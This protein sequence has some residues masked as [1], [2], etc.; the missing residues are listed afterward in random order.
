[1]ISSPKSYGESWTVG[2]HGPY[3]LNS[4]SVIHIV[5]SLCISSAWYSGTAVTRKLGIDDDTVN[6]RA[7]HGVVLRCCLKVAEDGECDRVLEVGIWSLEGDVSS[8]LTSGVLMV[9][10]LL[11]EM[12]VPLFHES[13]VITH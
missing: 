5:W 4:F 3:E 11:V 7:G 12:L 8:M 2:S 13:M 6:G 9:K 10:A 1:M